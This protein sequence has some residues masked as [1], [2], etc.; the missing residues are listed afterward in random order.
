MLFLR[1]VLAERY[2]QNVIADV[3]P[4]EPLINRL[5]VQ[6]SEYDF[7]SSVVNNNKQRP[8]FAFAPNA[9]D[10]SDIRNLT[11]K[12]SKNSKL[13]AKPLTIISQSPSVSLPD[14]NNRNR[15][16]IDRT[17]NIPHIV[18]GD[19]SNGILQQINFSKIDMP[20]VREARH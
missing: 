3:E 6:S 11:R 4:P 8:N 14:R 13:F 9:V 10:I 20:G 1:D 12:I 15:R 18:F 16:Q 19:A 17:N 7:F 2:S 5:F